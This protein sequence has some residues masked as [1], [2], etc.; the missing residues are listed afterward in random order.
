MEP[1]ASVASIHVDVKL[2]SISSFLSF[3]SLFFPR[4]ESLPI[5]D[6]I[7]AAMILVWVEFSHVMQWF[8]SWSLFVWIGKVSY[9]F[10]LMQF[11]TIYGLMPHIALHF[12]DQG[13]T[14]YW[15]IV[16]PT[17]ILCLMFNFFVAW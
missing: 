3:D 17:Y 1:F 13:K 6:R 16:T 12:V 9:G 14:Q 8:I 15:S 10:Y 5:F 7:P 2:V 11:L 4:P